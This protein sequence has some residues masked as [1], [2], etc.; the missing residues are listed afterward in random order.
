MG[1][2]DSTPSK[3]DCLMN[4]LEV[5]G[6][7]LPKDTTHGFEILDLSGERLMFFHWHENAKEDRLVYGENAVTPDEYENLSDEERLT[8]VMLP[9]GLNPKE[10]FE[11]HRTSYADVLKALPDR[12]AAIGHERDSDRIQGQ[13]IEM[14]GAG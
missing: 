4:I 14:F 10:T 9:E 6:D 7:K 11:H 12:L 2:T 5:K 3:K 8:V 13:V 1:L